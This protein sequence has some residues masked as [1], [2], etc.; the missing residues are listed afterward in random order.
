M[1]YF[2]PAE[3]RS[4]KI[5]SFNI[6]YQM[7]ILFC[8]VFIYVGLALG[9]CDTRQVG[10]SAETISKKAGNMESL[11]SATTIQPKIPPIDAAA[12]PE[13]ETATFALG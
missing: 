5:Y 4:I 2:N 10:A 9:G 7:S 3:S 1:K 12:A 6:R 13:M 11:Q 8:L